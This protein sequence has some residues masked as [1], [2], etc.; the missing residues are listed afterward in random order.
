[1]P[2]LV[3]CLQS[4]KVRR[5]WKTCLSSLVISGNSGSKTSTTLST[6]IVKVQHTIKLKNFS[7]YCTSLFLGKRLSAL[8]ILTWPISFLQTH[9]S[10][11][12]LC[13]HVLCTAEFRSFSRSFK[14]VDLLLKPLLCWCGCMLWVI[15]MLKGE[16]LFIFKP[17][18]KSMHFFLYLVVVFFFFFLPYNIP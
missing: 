11:I 12:S 2:G 16:F 8:H 17:C 18:F 9:S 4:V 3:Q 7:F 6:L 15:V 13:R 1:M 10:S 5:R 14:Y